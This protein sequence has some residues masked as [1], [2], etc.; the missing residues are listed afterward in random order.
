LSLVQA[1]VELHHGDIELADNHPG[2]KVIVRL[3][4]GDG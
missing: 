4:L 3:P 2:L 1:V